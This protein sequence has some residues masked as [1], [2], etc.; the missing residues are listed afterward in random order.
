[1]LFNTDG[2]FTYTPN[3]GFTG[4]VY[5][6]YK[7]CENADPNICDYAT[8]YIN[9]TNH[10]AGTYKAA[11]VGG[12]AKMDAVGIGTWSASTA[13]PG[14]AF[15]VSAADPFTVIRDFSTQ[16]IYTFYWV[17]PDNLIDYV[18]IAVFSYASLSLTSTPAF[19]LC[20]GTSFTIDANTNGIV[21]SWHSDFFNLSG[22]TVPI[23]ISP[24]LKNF[25]TTDMV[26]TFEVE[27]EDQ[28]RNCVTRESIPATLKPAPCV[29]ISPA[30]RVVCDF[31][32]VKLTATPV[33]PGTN[34]TWTA[35]DG[36]NPPNN[37]IGS[38]NVDQT[39]PPGNYIFTFTGELNGCTCVQTVEVTVTQ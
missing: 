11:C 27:V 6:D 13:N 31:R 24:T 18:Q 3:T 5:F 25:G 35:V 1:L 28:S 10:S 32:E 39:F 20:S 21:R 29:L 8:A 34:V 22:N 33:L 37:Y 9:I 15:I 7:I 14:T 4:V 17:S 26:V 2:T 19:P 38:G 16:G 23:S 12:E 30:G 36:A